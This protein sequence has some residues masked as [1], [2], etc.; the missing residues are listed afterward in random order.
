MRLV[1]T[2][3]LVFASAA[4]A[5]A[6]SITPIH[7][8]NHPAGS[9]KT[10]DCDHCPALKP[11]ASAST[12]TVPELA[13]GTQKTEIVDIN[14]QKKLVRTEAWLGGSPV[15]HVSTLPAWMAEDKAVTDIRPTTDGSTE[16]EIVDTVKPADGIDTSA[17][18]SAVKAPSDVATADSAAAPQALRLD[19][20]QLRTN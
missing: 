13:P 10:L 18:T 5:F 8:V 14:G 4:T 9:I 2:T 7:G 15:V 6:S 11:K 3:A 1:L 17:T 16:K 20:F 12:Y 19:A